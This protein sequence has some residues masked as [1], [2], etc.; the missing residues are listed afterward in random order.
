[1]VVIVSG[2]EKRMLCDWFRGKGKR[3]AFHEV[4]TGNDL[5]NLGIAAEHGYN[6]CLPANFESSEN[7]NS[8]AKQPEKWYTMSSDT[9]IPVESEEEYNLLWK[10]SAKKIMQNY[11]TQVANSFIELKESGVVWQYRENYN[12][13]H[14]L[15]QQLIIELEQLC[16]DFPLKIT[17]G[18]GYVEIKSNF[19]DKGCFAQKIIDL[20]FE[21]RGEFP[22]FVFCC[23]DDTADELMF[24]KVNKLRDL[25]VEEFQKLTKTKKKDKENKQSK[26]NN[27]NSCENSCKN[28]SENFVETHNKKLFENEFDDS[29]NFGSSSLG[30]S[31]QNTKLKSK[32][33]GL[34][35]MKSFGKESVLSL[36]SLGND[37]DNER[38]S[39]CSNSPDEDVNDPNRRYLSVTVGGKVSSAKCYVDDVQSLAEIVEVL[40]RHS[41]S[42]VKNFSQSKLV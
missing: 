39:S 37:D 15:K 35:S 28:S 42:D 7:S 6:F 27:S 38:T 18:K 9:E 14:Y 40:A 30:A 17:F 10:L 21:K 22:D 8:I 11:V 1:M 5:S 16:I 41:E 36:C 20:I 25:Q 23:G 12:A 24:E 19:V 2:R 13:G 29:N 33:F 3:V 34:T 4:E 31:L 26:S 32:N